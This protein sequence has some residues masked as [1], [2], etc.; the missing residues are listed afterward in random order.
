MP[1]RSRPSILAGLI[2]A[3][4]SVAGEL[5][6]LNPHRALTQ[7][8]RTVWTQ[9]QGLPQDTIRAIAQTQDGYLW[10]GTNEG[11]VRFDGYE[12]VTHTTDDGSLPNNVVTALAAGRSGALWIGTVDGL[13]RYANGKFTRFTVRDGLPAK[14]INALIEDHAGVLW[15][16][17]GGFLARFEN[18]KFKTY[19]QDRVAP[20]QTVQVVYEDPQQQLWVGGAGGL[21]KRAGDGFS[22]VLG[23]LDL[24]DNF[25]N[26]ILKDNAGLWVAAGDKGIV[27]V[28]SGGGLKWFGA[29]EGLPNTLVRALCEDRAGNLWAGTNGGLSRLENGRF[30]SPSPD[31]KSDSDWVWSLFEDREGD[32]W[33]GMN[34]ALNRFRD[35]PFL[36]YGRDEGLPSDQPT[37]VHQDPRGEIWVGYHDGGLVALSPGP[38]RVY[39]MREGLPSNEILGIRHSRDGDLLIGTRGGLSRMHDGRFQNY[40]APDPLGPTVAYDAL[41]DLRGHLWIAGVHGVYEWDGSRWR[42]K[43]ETNY[44]VALA[45]DRNGSIWAGTLA[46]VLWLVRDGKAP[47]AA[48]RVYATADRLGSGHVRSLYPDRDGTLWIGT[49]GGG[50][51]SVRNGVFHRWG[52]RDGLLSDNISHVE[53]DG[54]GNLWLSTS[55]G[56]CQISKQQLRDFSAGKIQALTPRNYGIEDGLRSA[57]CAPG[58]PAGGGGTRTADGHLWFPTARG[59]AT[60]DPSAVTRKVPT[61]P[62]SRIIEVDVDGRVLDSSSSAKLKPGTSRI[63]FRYTGINLSTP[64]RVRYSTLL[65]GLDSDWIPAGGRR[66]ITYNPLRHGRYRFMVRSSLPGGSESESQFAFEV[67]PHFYETGWFFALCAASVIGG[68]LGIYQLHL[69][70]IHDRF[71]LVLE[72]R[73]RLAREIHDTL[74]Q[75]FVGISSQLDALAIKLDEDPAVV[76]EG[77]DLARKMARHSLTEARRSVMDLRTSDLEQQDLL[78]ALE[79]S[80]H[81]WVA[82]SAVNVRV[83]VSRVTRKIPEDLEQNL[84]RIAQEAVANALKHAHASTIWV[85]VE[86]EDRALRLRVKDDG[87]GFEPPAAFSIVGGHFGILGMRERAERL[88]GKFHLASCPGSGTQVEV[89]VPFAAKNAANN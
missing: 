17:A 27:L 84:L 50:L 63:Q 59:L 46:T 6:A 5:A 40:P 62:I 20:I 64:E 77:L 7:Y 1:R 8:T 83:D 72:E 28:Q 68:T 74:A 37:V 2:L 58:F 36:V 45:E 35:D 55:R 61:T 26:A 14:P 29:G 81:R 48:P 33:V 10:L 39:S 79:A 82:G 76:R 69:R 71:A 43:I 18:G 9:A 66:V 75:G 32:L 87:R 31:V 34:S 52:M 16:A 38:S 42:A 73:G 78:G 24:G 30:V 80:T 4:V 57:Q 85:E 15:V 11:L 13:S 19:S 70:Q 88:G 47:D 60:V 25:I 12:F 49:F 65:E 3:F 67:L 41:E 86:A 56:I 51:S 21:I 89:R 44:P 23:P 22:A 53:D 54:K